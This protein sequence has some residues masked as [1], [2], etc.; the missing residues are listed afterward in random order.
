[1]GPHHGGPQLQS[2]PDVD[3][4]ASI[5]QRSVARLIVICGLALIVAGGVVM[6]GTLIPEATDNRAVLAA[7]GIGIV[8]FLV[9]FVGLAGFYV[10]PAASKTRWVDTKAPV[11]APDL[12]AALE[13]SLKV[14][15]MESS[16]A[17]DEEILEIVQREFESPSEREP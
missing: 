9:V 2:R 8:G 13:A 12:M 16:E 4:V 1:M 17:T 3:Y 10:S 14:A 5:Q 15:R 7:S 6:A 11:R